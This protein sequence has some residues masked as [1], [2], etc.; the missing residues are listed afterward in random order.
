MSEAAEPDVMSEVGAVRQLVAETN[1]AVVV[2][3][4]KT[5]WQDTVDGWAVDDAGRQVVTRPVAV[6]VASAELG[7]ASELVLEPGPTIV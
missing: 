1:A 6:V 5:A 2:V 4:E 3:A 7:L